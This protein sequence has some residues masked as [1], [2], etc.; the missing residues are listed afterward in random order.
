MNMLFMKHIC[1]IAIDKDNKTPC[2]LHRTKYL[3]GNSECDH[4]IRNTTKIMGVLK[5]TGA[6]SDFNETIFKTTVTKIWI[7]KDEDMIYEM[8]NGL[9]LRIKKEEVR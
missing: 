6:I 7:T 2:C 9:K 5:S 1:F 8:K 4:L 3:I